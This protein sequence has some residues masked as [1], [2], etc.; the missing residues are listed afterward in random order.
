LAIPGVPAPRRIVEWAVDQ[1]RKVRLGGF[2]PK[3][4]DF[5]ITSPSTGQRITVPAMRLYVRELDG[6]TG[7]WEWNLVS[8]QGMVVMN[9]ILARPDWRDLLLEVTRQG[10]PPKTQWIVRVL[11]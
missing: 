9:E 8:K 1:T 3:L 5:S 11:K 2:E 7:E 10:A 6:Q 4:V